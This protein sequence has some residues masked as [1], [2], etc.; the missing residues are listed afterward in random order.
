MITSIR[1]MARHP[2]SDILLQLARHTRH[3]KR[4]TRDSFR[5]ESVPATSLCI[6][7]PARKQAILFSSASLKLLFYF[8]QSIPTSLLLI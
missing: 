5:E 3:V 8:V 2:A 4:V 6:I 1:R 7:Y